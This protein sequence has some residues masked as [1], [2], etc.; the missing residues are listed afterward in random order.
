[1]RV[2]GF[3]VRR[4]AAVGEHKLGEVFSGLES[5]SALQNVF[6]SRAEMSK[7]LRHLKLRVEPFES[8]LWLDRDTGTICIGYKHLSTAKSDFLYLDVIH[9]LVHVRQFLEG[10]E[11]YDQAFEYVERPTE[12][13]AYRHTVAEARRVG[14]NEDEILKYLRLDAA[15]DSE[16]GKL[17]EKI[18]V[19]AR[20]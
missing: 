14:L 5:S 7:T 10:R 8:G 17:M 13:E 11:L 15:D 1:M 3:R 12:L 2:R 19:K 6:G 20:R 4:A 18:G 9:V 16:L